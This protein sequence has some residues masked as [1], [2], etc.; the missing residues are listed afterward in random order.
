MLGAVGDGVE[1]ETFVG[2]VVIAG[3]G[4]VVV[5]GVSVATRVAVVIGVPVAGGVDV[6]IGVV[7]TAGSGVLVAL[8]IRVATGVRV[9]LHPQYGETTGDPMDDWVPV[10]DSAV[11]NPG[12]IATTNPA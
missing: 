4:V 3:P 7:V 9:P 2:V 8:G 12:P 5:I 1:F 6:A 10:D 11:A